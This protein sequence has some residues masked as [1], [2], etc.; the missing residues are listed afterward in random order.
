MWVERR[1]EVGPTAHTIDA[2]GIEVLIEAILGPLGLR[3]DRTTPTVDA[4]LADGSRVNIVVPPLAIDGPA[5]SI[6]RFPRAAL[7]LGRFGPPNLARL[8]AGLVAARASILV[9]GPTSSGKTSLV[10][11]LAA[12]TDPTERI[13]C[14]EDTA[15]LPIDRPNLV[16]L[17]ARPANSEGVGEV[18]LRR[19]VLT[20][21][22]MRPDRLV[23]GEVR[24]PEAFDLL[25]A[26]TSG[27]RGSLTTCHA[28]DAAGG[29]RR[30]STL[31]ALADTGLEPAVLRELV[32]DGLDVVVVTGRRGAERSVD[33]VA[34]VDAAGLVPLWSPL[35]DRDGPAAGV[36]VGSEA[37]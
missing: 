28:A 31:A 25:L 30:L 26:L 21:L 10:A 24:G 6:R 8:L 34:R 14:I 18:T 29:L 4:R 2:T 20:A 9:V 7:P 17:E 27:H 15:E 35:A 23:V 19:L 22:R 16:R 36:G 1:G 32:V 13:V 5:V 12:L 37:A 33:A 11:S 3:V